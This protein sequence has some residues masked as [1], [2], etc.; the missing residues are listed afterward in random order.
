M[1]HDDC[2][3]NFRTSDSEVMLQSER[4]RID[5]ATQQGCG[6]THQQITKDKKV[7]STNE[8]SGDAFFKL[9]FSKARD[10]HR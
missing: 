1:R 4:V 8:M 7:K 10:Q 9:D 5:L 2:V 3:V 6:F